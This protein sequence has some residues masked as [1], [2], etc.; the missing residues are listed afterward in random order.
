MGVHGRHNAVVELAVEARPGFDDLDVGTEQAGIGHLRAGADAAMLRLVARG[1]EGRGLRQHGR[2]TDGLAAQLQ[3][4][5]L[6][7]AGEIGIHVHESPEHTN[8]IGTISRRES[9]I[10]IGPAE[11]AEPVLPQGNTPFPGRPRSGAEGWGSKPTTERKRLRG[12]CG[13]RV[14]ADH[15]PQRLSAPPLSHGAGGASR[16]Q[17][18][19]RR[20][21]AR[22][23]ERSWIHV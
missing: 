16:P 2:H 12:A 20:S 3:A 5:L 13:P 23:I 1:D 17:G 10:L 11:A 19:S 6:L 22:G 18:L 8:K 14:S 15:T 7:A 21:A 9:M 4:V